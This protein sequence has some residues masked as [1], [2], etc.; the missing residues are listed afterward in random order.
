MEYNL[1]DNTPNQPT[2]SRTINWA[3]INDESN[4]VLVASCW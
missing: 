1:V 3:K 2:K 4:G